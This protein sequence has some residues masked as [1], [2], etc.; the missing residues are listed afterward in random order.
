[1]ALRAW[2]GQLQSLTVGKP[3]AF[4]ETF[5][6][7]LVKTFHFNLLIYWVIVS[8]SH[9]FD[10]Y[11][12]VQERELR[13]AELERSLSQARLQALQMQ[14][15]PHFLFNTLHAISSL[16]HKDAEAADRMISRLSDLLRYTLESTAEHE[17][18]LEQELQVLDRYLEIEQTRF[19]A[20]LSVEKQIAPE[21][22][23]VL[24]PNLILQ[25]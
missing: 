10:Y 22:L 4:A 11:R 6:P 9:T 24:V 14:L 1:M 12:Q 20:R 5:N 25:P 8:V 15:N 18:P 16:V 17:V 2:V 23:S 13:A 7:L 3:V 19:G 21:T